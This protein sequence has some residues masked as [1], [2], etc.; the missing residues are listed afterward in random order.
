M[1]LSTLGK[2][3]EAPTQLGAWRF[4]PLGT[5]VS[6][7][8]VPLPP[9]PSIKHLTARFVRSLSSTN[10]ICP[11]RRKLRSTALSCQFMADNSFVSF[12]FHPHSLPASWS[13]VGCGGGWN[14]CVIKS[15]NRVQLTSEC[16]II[17][18]YLTAHWI[19]VFWLLPGPRKKTRPLPPNRYNFYHNH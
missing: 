10:L 15:V 11:A 8:K 5:R 19:C 12:P 2:T 4:S 13:W 6:H 7:I 9:P 17:M 16:F 1:F 18:K 14:L 3:C